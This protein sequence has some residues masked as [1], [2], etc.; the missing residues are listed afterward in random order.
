M[1]VI[2]N[3]YKSILNCCRYFLL[4]CLLASSL[5]S[6]DQLASIAASTTPTIKKTATTLPSP[7]ITIT[8]SPTRTLTDR[9]TNFPS[10]AYTY[11]LPVPFTSTP[12]T[13][14]CWSKGGHIETESLRTTLLR[15]A[16]EYRI[17]LPPCYDQ[18]PRR[19]YPV[20]YLF[21]GQN[22]KDDQWERLGAGK[23]VDELVLAG[24]IPPFIIVMPRERYE[25]GPSESKFAQVIVDIL[26]PYIDSQY[27]TLPER[28]SRAIGGLSRGAGWAVH[29]AVVYWEI[30]GALGAHSLAIFRSDAQYLPDWLDAIPPGSYPRIYIDLGDRD[31]DEITQ[32]ALW[33]E[34]MLD[35]MDIPHEFHLFSGYHA[36][37]YWQSHLDQYLRWYAQGW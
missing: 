26:V 13:L 21:H 6:C 28:S 30:F 2:H 1:I 12:T 23:K 4:I 5:V 22:Y 34:K 11:P 32:P 25:G 37:E 18:Q 14:A 29:L 15:F 10:A 9:P 20:L 16:L 27:R 33:F 19:R 8:K 24:E 36:E 3:K 31:W 35:E 17:Y 7:T